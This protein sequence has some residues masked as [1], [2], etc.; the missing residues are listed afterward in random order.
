[1]PRS[2]RQKVEGFVSILWQFQESQCQIVPANVSFGP[3]IFLVKPLS[4]E[5]FTRNGENCLIRNNDLYDKISKKMSF[6]LVIK[7]WI[8]ISLPDYDICAK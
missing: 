3:T 5:E 2:F 6:S 8:G 1:M 4:N 7:L